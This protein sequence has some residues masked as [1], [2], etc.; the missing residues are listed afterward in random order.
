ML[1]IKIHLDSHYLSF[2]RMNCRFSVLSSDWKFNTP[3]WELENILK[4]C[5]IYSY[6]IIYISLVWLSSACKM[7]FRI[8]PRWIASFYNCALLL[9]IK[10]HCVKRRNQHNL[11]AHIHTFKHDIVQ[12]FFGATV[13]NTSTASGYEYALATPKFKVCILAFQTCSISRLNEYLKRNGFK[14]TCKQNKTQLLP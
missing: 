12:I 7:Y 4:P 6:I 10:R 8:Q 5:R 3:L 9:F 2:W 11:F 1:L 14:S 13:W